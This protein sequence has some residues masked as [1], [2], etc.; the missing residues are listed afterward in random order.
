MIIFK[1]NGEYFVTYRLATT[2]E[3]DSVDFVKGIGLSMWLGENGKIY[4][5]FTSFHIQS[6]C[7]EVIRVKGIL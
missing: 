6:G 2:R 4:R 5:H 1:D 3:W 7:Y